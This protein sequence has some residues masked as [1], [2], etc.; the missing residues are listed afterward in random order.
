MTTKVAVIGGGSWG[1]TL[2][3]LL[4]SRTDTV[5][6]AREAEVVDG[7]REHHRNPLFVS[8][9]LLD[10]RLGATDDVAEALNGADVVLVAVPS[11]YIRTVMAGA[12]AHV[13]ADATVLSVTKGLEL[14]TG[15]RMTEVLDEV[16]VG[17]PSAAIGTLSGPNLAREVM[18]G[19]P[20]ATCVAFASASHAERVQDLLMGDTLRVYTSDD[21]IGCEV[22][23]AVKNVIA[24]AAGVADGLGY[25]INT[26]ATLITRGLAELTR[27]GVALGGKTLTFLGLSG[28]GDLIAT[29]TSV[30]SRNHTVGEAL[31]KGRAISEIVHDMQMV[32]EGVDTAPA[33]LEQATR[34]GIDMPIT[35]AVV[36]LL[37][38]HMTASELVLS[39]MRRSPK[40]ET[41]GLAE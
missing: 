23:G 12:R 31:A 22:G 40:S 14:S 24:I 26:K 27:L 18:S 39:L 4:A 38:G 36:A 2:A 34:L 33:V 21:V 6:W 20:A 7:I 16:L 28:N 8:D 37:Q 5:I 32:A 29:C 25:G 41:H 15:R 1:T 30:E 11:Q 9:W 3:S 10:E 13:R 17:H 19:H 35:A